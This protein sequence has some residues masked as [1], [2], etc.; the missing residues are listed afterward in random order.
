MSGVSTAAFG[1]HKPMHQ[2][3]IIVHT[4]SGIICF[5]AG[6]VLLSRL[7]AR[8]R[9]RPWLAAYGAGLIGLVV[10]MGVAIASHWSR[11]ATA[12]QAAYL[13]LSALA[14]YMVRR[15]WG[16]WRAWR[17]ADPGWRRRFVDHVGF[18]LISLFDGFAIVLAIDLG[19]P[20][21]LVAAVGAA[22]IAAGLLAV[23]RV[24]R[25]AHA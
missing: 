8:A 14:A 15:G 12:R 17:T 1:E 4:I 5:A 22:G 16:A 19:A 25:R 2:A 21:W 13:G 9:Q 24:R 3:A 7:D 18:T 23:G 6:C 10:F 11:L 20:G